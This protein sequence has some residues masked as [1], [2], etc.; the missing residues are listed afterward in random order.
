MATR[1]PFVFVLAAIIPTMGAS[2][3]TTNFTVEAPTPEIAE[4]VGQWAE[5]YRREKAREWLGREMPN[6]PEPCPLHVRVTPTGAGGAT[7]F[8]F[9]AGHVWQTMEIE[10]PIDRL[11][12]SV[13]P[14]EVTHTVFAHYFRC[15]VPRWADEGGAVLSEDDLERNNH[16]MMARQIL[17]SGRA[18]PLSYLF[19]LKNYPR[20]PRDIGALYA[21]GYSVSSFLVASSNRKV[22]LEFLGHGMNY[23]WDTALRTYYGYQNVEQLQQ[24]WINSLRA[25]RTQA[26]TMLAHNSDAAAPGEQTRGVLVRLTA[27]PV[28]PLLE[29]P[30]FVARGQAPE[31]DP[32]AGFRDAPRQQMEE[33]P[34]YLPDANAPGQQPQPV[35]QNAWVPAV[36]LGQ[37]VAGPAYQVQ[38]AV[39]YGQPASQP[40]PFYSAPA[41]QPQ[42]IYS[43]PAACPPTG[44]GH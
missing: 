11:I 29:E 16:D 35:P 23:G 14:H 19:G 43:F 39:V 33:R 27:P 22:F 10:G 34:G 24:A 6:W 12:A 31:Y 1:R 5:H 20:D 32:R 15:P 17:N 28:Q 26:P 2:F 13:L 37:P 30:G 42:A 7:S 36:R 38:P 18:L 25:P 44:S 3:R 21:E 8:N 4:R 9:T 41:A 40:A